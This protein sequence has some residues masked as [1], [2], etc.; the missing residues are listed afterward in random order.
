M[1][2]PAMKNPA[3]GQRQTPVASRPRNP[4]QGIPLDTVGVSSSDP[5]ELAHDRYKPPSKEVAEMTS[6]EEIWTQYGSGLQSFLRS[7][8]SSPEDAEDLLQEILVKTHANLH[9]LKEDSSVKAWLMQV[10][11]RVIIDFYRKRKRHPEELSDEGEWWDEHNLETDRGLARCVRPFL[12]ALR[13]DA[14][15]L[16]LAI[17]LEGRSQKEVAAELGLSYSTVKSRV[18]RARR[19]LR[20]IAN[21]CCQLEVD[22]RGK[23]IDFQPRSNSCKL[24]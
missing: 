22:G 21:R 20:K 10:A 6:T 15:E 9:T 24:C 14:A 18:Q 7:K 19:E 1:T 13:D 11:N 2:N 23:V 3:V 16:L 5:F 12:G 8:V 17:D 4:S